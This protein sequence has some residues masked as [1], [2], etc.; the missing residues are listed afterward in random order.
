M[1]RAI[2]TERWGF[3]GHSMSNS[4]DN[5]EARLAEWIQANTGHSGARIESLLSGGNSNLTLHIAT[6]EGTLV[7][8]TP[9]ENAISPKAHRGIEREAR[10]MRALHG[11]VKVPEVIGFCADTAVIGRPFLLVSMV[12]G[13]SITD[14]LPAAYASDET[15]VNRLGEGLIDELA[16]IHNVAW[17]RA[18]LEGFG[19]PDGFL[20]RQ[21]ERWRE[22]RASAGGRDLPLIEELGTWLA[23]RLPPDP[24]QTIVHGDYHL[25]NTLT[26]RDRPELA[27]VIDWEMAT[28]G[29]PLTDLGLLLMFWGPRSIEP[30]GFAQ[31]QAVSRFPGAVSRRDLA[32][33]WSERTGIGLEYLDFYLC[34]AFWR[35]AAVVEGAFQLYR[36]GEIDSEYARGLEYDVPALLAEAAAAAAGEW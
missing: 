7:L 28:L 24:A 18:G 6:H 9:P 23:S 29:D 16:A 31:V 33:R 20:A 10:V 4:V 1:G 14:T 27:A 30:P 26:R 34:F 13:V 15:A 17:Q 11:T 3:L 12:D 32:R 5:P 8:R 36:K 25:D 19:K 35:L 2:L 22:I 21:V